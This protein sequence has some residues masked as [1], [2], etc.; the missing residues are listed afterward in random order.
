MKSKGC[1]NIKTLGEN[2][3]AITV[4][5]TTQNY[6]FYYILSFRKIEII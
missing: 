5:N 3:K 1:T 6:N 2:S 4:K